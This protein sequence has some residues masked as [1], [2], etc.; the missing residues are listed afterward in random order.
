MFL[1]S[2]ATYGLFLIIS[3]GRERAVLEAVGGDPEVQLRGEEKIGQQIWKEKRRFVYSSLFLV[4]LSL[5]YPKLHRSVF[6]SC[7]KIRIVFNFS[8]FKD[9]T[10]N[11]FISMQEDTYLTSYY[12][13]FLILFSRFQ[14]SRRE[15]QS[16]RNAVQQNQNHI[17]ANTETRYATIAF[18]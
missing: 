9:F 14:G 18:L 17:A 6:V 11:G 2:A 7:R 3:V 13:V 1:N 10:G 8:I 16:P 15:A 4:Y 5:V 12:K